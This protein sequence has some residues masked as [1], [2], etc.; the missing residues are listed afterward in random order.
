MDLTIG[1][2]AEILKSMLDYSPVGTAFRALSDATRLALFERLS[3]GPAS[4]SQLAEPFAVS[5][6]AI[7]QHLEILES[8][9]LIT[10]EKIGRVRTCRVDPEGLKLLSNWVAERRSS[11]ERRL[12]RLAELLDAEDQ[13]PTRPQDQSGSEHP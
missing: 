1:A 11:M 6:T 10:S 8:C 4:V 13:P 3:R 7:G 9:G 2:R 12:D 5:L